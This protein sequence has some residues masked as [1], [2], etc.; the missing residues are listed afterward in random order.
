M[1]DMVHVALVVGEL[2]T[3]SANCYRALTLGNDELARE[4][5]EMACFLAERLRVEVSE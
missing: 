1:S 2:I 3:V 4:C 5:A